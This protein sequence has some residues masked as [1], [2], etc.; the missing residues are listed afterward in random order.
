MFDEDFRKE[1][2]FTYKLIHKKGDNHYIPLTEEELEIILDEFYEHDGGSDVLAIPIFDEKVKT[3]DG[4][5]IRWLSIFKAMRV[6]RVFDYQ[7]DAM[8][9][10]KLGDYHVQ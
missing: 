5:M 8:N 6:M 10:L 9:V 2:P 7:A 1:Y 3:K 4:K